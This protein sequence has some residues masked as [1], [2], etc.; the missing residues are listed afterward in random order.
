MSIVAKQIKPRI[1]N[2]ISHVVVNL[3]MIL[4][5][6][7]LM[8]CASR[9][10]DAI[11]EGSQSTQT[12]GGTQ[13]GSS[14]AIPSLT[15]N[16][17]TA[18]TATPSPSQGPVSTQAAIT[19]TF[20][21][22]SD[23]HVRQSKPDTNYGNESTLDVDSGNDP[24]ESLIHFTITD[25]SGTVLNARL[26]IYAK[27]NGS[28]DGPAVYATSASWTEDEITWNNHPMPSS[29]ELDNSDQI[30]PE[31]WVEY[32][33]TPAVTGPGAVSFSLAAD[34]GDAIVFSS[35]EGNHPPELVVTFAPSEAPAPMPTLSAE[36]VTFVGAGDISTCTNDNDEL[37]ARLLDNIPG[38]VFTTGD[39]VDEIG[40]Y[41]E[42][43]NC[44]DPTWGRHKDRTNPVPGDHEYFASDSSGYFQYFN[45]PPYYAYNL[46]SWRIYGLNSEI[47]VEEDSKQAI[48]LKL[49]LALNPN[50][51]VLAFWHRPRWSSGSTYGNNMRMQTIWKILYDAGAE[52]V[53]NG[54]EQ[55]YER[56][57]PMDADGLADP[58][59]MREFVV[60]TGG[61]ALYPFG[62]PL[63]ASQVRNDST[64]GVLKLTL[65]P[66]RYD[67]EFVP[68]AGSTFTDSG[69]TECH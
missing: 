3:L 68:V 49:D 44:Y 67:W 7:L 25:V 47:G 51:C 19:L 12:S 2:R 55:N 1:P 48:W 56:F 20:L 33:V 24:D 21:S 30:N 14:T 38:V 60:G 57:M 4:M 5:I 22:D 43:M 52:L 58:F 64:Y 13:A 61:G 41:S 37:T 63:P 62:S 10:G 46:G 29:N 23:T 32:D 54:N 18:P 9:N 6:L 59:G 17:T 66:D 69:S 26:R 28:L 34:S 53:L 36:D 11:S 42:F 15:A 35:R 39:N 27:T 45:V 50:K 40:T 8:G 16:N 31:S 65:R